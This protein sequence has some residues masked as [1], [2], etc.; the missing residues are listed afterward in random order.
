VKSSRRTAAPVAVSALA[1][2]LLGACGPTDIT[3]E[4]LEHSLSV[5]FPNYY[6]QQQALLGHPAIDPAAL[7][8]ILSCDKGGPNNPDKGA[9][10]DWICIADWT[11]P[12]KNIHYTDADPNTGATK[13]EVKINSDACYSAGGSSKV[14]GPQQLQDPSGRY[15]NNPMFEFDACFDTSDGRTRT[16]KGVIPTPVPATPTPTPTPT[17]GT[18]PTTEPTTAPTT[19]PTA[20]STSSPSS[21][22]SPTPSDTPSELFPEPS[23]TPT[24]S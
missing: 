5:V 7:H 3:A 16:T 4:R 18:E 22:E 21:T 20:A 23:G 19:E 10:N 6:A 12:V 2:P 15:V 14:F 13:F 24:A 1:V 11:D 9:G 8:P 17:P